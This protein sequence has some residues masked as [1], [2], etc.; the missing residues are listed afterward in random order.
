MKIGPIDMMRNP[1]RQGMR[2]FLGARQA[3]ITCL[4]VGAVIPIAAQS[5]AKNGEWTTYGGDLGNTRYSPLAQITAE[6]FN[7]LEVAWRFKTDSLGPRPEYQY[8]STPLVVHGILY[9]TGGSRRAAVAMDAGTGELLWVHSENEGER[10]RNAP[11]Q[12]SGRGLAY[13]TDGR[14]ER[15]I[16]VTPG[17]RMVALNAKNGQLITSFGT[18]GIV[19]LKLDDDQEMDLVTAEVGLHAAPVV[20]GNVVIIGAAHKTGGAPVSMRHVKG[21]VRG[22]DVR[23]GKRLWIFH[24]I[25]QAGEF[26]IDTGKTTHGRYTGNTGVWAQSLAWMKNWVWHTFPWS[27]PPGT[28]MEDIVP[29]TACSAKAWSPSMLKTGKKQVALS[30]CSPRPLGHGYSAARRFSSDITINGRTVKAA[31]RNP[32]S[33]LSSMC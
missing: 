4:F 30:T 33:N 31:A 5:G 1:E 6:N 15:I 16:Y 24:T 12:L 10:G 22:F 18:N 11:R 8:E 28:P 27:C 26:G 3:L 9:T 19:D 14:E 7:K 21:Y 25:P 17:Y 13:W 23:T 32:R 2:G 29:E 20:S